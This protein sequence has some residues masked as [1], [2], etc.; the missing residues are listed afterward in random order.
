MLRP[1]VYIDPAW[2]T[3]KGCPK[4][5]GNDAVERIGKARWIVAMTVQKGY[6][7]WAGSSG[8]TSEEGKKAGQ[9]EGK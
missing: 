2:A 6:R 9:D 8:E 1:P 5:Q 7:A 3:G 4:L